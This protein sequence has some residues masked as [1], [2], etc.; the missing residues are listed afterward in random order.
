M[1][2][3]CA[4]CETVNKSSQYTH[5]CQFSR[6]CR[7]SGIDRS[8]YLVFLLVLPFPPSVSFHQCS[9]LH[10]HL[11]LDTTT[12]I[13]TSGQNLGKFKQS[14][15]LLYIVRVLSRTSTFTM[16]ILRGLVCG[17]HRRMLHGWSQDGAHIGLQPNVNLILYSMFIIVCRL[18]ETNT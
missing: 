17:E 5:E 10:I 8:I 6:L 9:M 3:Q 11:H 15:A 13:R 12:V 1:H 2:T 4:L 16:S 18:H 14:N 7:G